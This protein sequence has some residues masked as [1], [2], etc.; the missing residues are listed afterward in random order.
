MAIEMAHY[1]KK[2]S[3]IDAEVDAGDAE[4]D[5]RFKDLGGPLSEGVIDLRRTYQRA[6][7]RSVDERGKEKMKLDWVNYFAGIK[8]YAFG[9]L[10][11]ILVLFG[12]VWMIIYGRSLLGGESNF[13]IKV[14][15]PGQATL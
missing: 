4:R 7:V 13:E 1:D 12:V 11:L 10:L 3:G 15:N 8:K 14:Q 5:F 9:A 6:M 2:I